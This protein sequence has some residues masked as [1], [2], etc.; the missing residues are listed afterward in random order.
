MNTLGLSSN[1]YYNIKR[2]TYAT[3][4]MLIAAILLSLNQSRAVE[5]S[6][7]SLIGTDSTSLSHAYTVLSSAKSQTQED[8]MAKIKPLTKIL[9]KSGPR[10][11]PCGTPYTISCRSL[12]IEPTLT[13][14]LQSADGKLIGRKLASSVPVYSHHMQRSGKTSASLKFSWEFIT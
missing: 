7:S 4:H 11:E 13:P 3:Y 12:N 9:K 2:N 10:T 14:I 6:F 1:V 5:I 8:L